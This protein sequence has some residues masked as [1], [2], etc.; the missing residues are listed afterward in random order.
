MQNEA[1]EI[2][3][4]ETFFNN[5]NP[6]RRSVPLDPKSY[7]LLTEKVSVIGRHIETLHNMNCISETELK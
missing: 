4:I 2:C 3:E 5:D 6:L 7:F 1:L